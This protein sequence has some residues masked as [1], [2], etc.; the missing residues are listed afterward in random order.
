MLGFSVDPGTALEGNGLI[1]YMRNFTVID[2]KC[3][4]KWGISYPEAVLFDW[5][6]S[7]PSWAKTAIV[8]NEVF[9]FASYQKA[10]SD[11]PA[12]TEKQDTM[13]RY[14]KRLEKEGLIRIKMIDSKAYIS[15]TEKA[16]EWNNHGQKQASDELPSNLGQPSDE[17]R[18]D[19]RHIDNNTI[20]SN[21]IDTPIVPAKK[22]KPSAYGPGFNFSRNGVSISLHDQ[23]AVDTYNRYYDGIDKGL[24][25]MSLYDYTYTTEFVLKISYAGSEFFLNGFATPGKIPQPEFDR[26]YKIAKMLSEKGLPCFETFFGHITTSKS[27]PEFNPYFK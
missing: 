21:S 3:V 1:V 11:L 24:T 17:P 6:Y 26:V 20:D 7:L 18:T 15:L 14:Y 16:K 5:I 25:G 13:Y 19:I 23:N 4:V 12:L 9:Y 27:L 22:L 8:E 10:C 2:N